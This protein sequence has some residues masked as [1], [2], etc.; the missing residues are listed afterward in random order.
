MKKKKKARKKWKA[1]Q[2]ESTIAVYIYIYIILYSLKTVCPLFHLHTPVSVLTCATSINRLTDGYLLAILPTLPSDGRLRLEG[3]KNFLVPE[4]CVCA[5]L[6]CRGRC[7]HFCVLR[8]GYL[9][10]VG[11]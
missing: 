4:T 1:Q 6:C 9:R 3:A 8:H 7:F 5:M 10:R 11:L 2:P